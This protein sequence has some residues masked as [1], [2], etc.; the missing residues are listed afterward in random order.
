[1]SDERDTGFKVSDRRKFNPDGTPKDPATVDE[2]PASE[3]PRTPLQAEP[4]AREEA[5]GSAGNVLSFPGETTKKKDA[6][7]G[8]EVIGSGIP[9]QASPRQ[10]A[11]AG[12]AK[13]YDNASNATQSRL[14]AASFLGLANML[15]V[16]AAMH[17]GLI[18]AGPGEE[19]TVD[20]DAARHVIDLLGILQEKT[21][22]NL[23]PEENT[24][25]D[26][27]LADLRMQ[28]VSASGRR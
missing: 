8:P 11:N 5:P 23:A 21:R 3:M 28:F 25:L 22:G 9:P 19:R 14:P 1:M 15:G 26:N 24:L 17:L 12:A 7:P 13:A 4:Q 6:E 27:M 10:S 16:E 20:L 2:A 18:E